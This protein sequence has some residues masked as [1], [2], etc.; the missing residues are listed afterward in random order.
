MINLRQFPVHIIA[1]DDNC[2]TVE[3]PSGRIRAVDLRN[4][5]GDTR[6]IE[7]ELIRARRVTKSLEHAQRTKPHDLP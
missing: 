5:T 3:F 2:A 6:E 4:L 7:H 1:A